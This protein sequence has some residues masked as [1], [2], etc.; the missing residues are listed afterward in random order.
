MTQEEALD[1]LKLG[2][3]VFLTGPPGSGKTFLLNKY[4]GYLK[5]H[6]KGVAITASTGIAATHMEG[7]TIHS[8]SGLGIK[9]ELTDGDIQ[10]LL[11]RPYLRKRF[12][13]TYVLL[14]DE[15]SML[16]AFQ[17][18]MLNRICQ[19]FKNSFEPFG[20]MQVVCS[21]DFFQLPPVQKQ[22]E[23]KFV[24]DSRAWQN[25]DLKICY[26]EEQ[27]RQKQD[28]VLLTLLSHIRNNAIEE[29]QKLLEGRECKEE[30]FP[31]VPTKLYT[32]NVD[33]DAINSFELG[34]I[35]QKEFVY[36][37][38]SRGNKNIAAALRKSCLA[39]ERLV[40]KKEAQVMFVKNNFGQGY[41][42][43]T[44]GKVVA[45]NNAH[46]PVIETLS[47]NFIAVRPAVWRIEEDD[48]V[49]AEISQ[50]PLRLAWAI[51][52]HK[53]QGMNLE[54]A[55]INL[56]KC[57]VEG[58][59]YVALSR[60]RSLSGLKL[61]G[62]NELAL[63]V[64]QDVLELD[65]EFKRLSFRIAGDFRK[66]ALQEKEGK[67]RQFLH[68]LPRVGRAQKEKKEFVS[69]YEKTRR[70]VSDKLPIKEIAKRRG[71]SEGTILSHLERLA[72]GEKELDLGYLRLLEERFQKIKAAFQQSEDVK[73]F[74]VREILGKGFSYQ[75]LRLAR[76]FLKQDRASKN[77]RQTPKESKAS[78]GARN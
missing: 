72:A 42:N 15:I 43:G 28:D 19:A 11:R 34:K 69:T 39:P 47:G 49:K 70:F 18:D 8:W 22:G 63:W 26:L 14:I 29:S 74:P 54:T 17:F 44:R 77:K 5:K 55:E 60:L 20:G 66:M 76:L 21:G 10:K 7:V 71:L 68:T 51:T 67:Q 62:V 36:Q 30:L 56:S 27:H 4:I 64:N 57:F 25:M 35:Q 48:K 12:A 13:A 6:R 53:S 61:L 24:T 46:L 58:M 75:E 40:L 31:V 2:Y 73:L 23:A 65:K 78:Y 32:H 33:V 38:T 16:H 50:V 1:I 59:G 52:V 41:V 37:M 9:E 45:F 3:N